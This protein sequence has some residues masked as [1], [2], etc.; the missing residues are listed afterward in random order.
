MEIVHEIKNSISLERRLCTQ[1]IF[2]KS[3]QHL[4]RKNAAYTGIV[5]EIKIATH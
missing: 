4:V 5:H 1:K 3:K 2:M